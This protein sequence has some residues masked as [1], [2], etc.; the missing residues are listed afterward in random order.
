MEIK[1]ELARIQ[2]LQRDGWASIRTP[3]NYVLV[4]HEY[5]FGCRLTYVKR[6]QQLYEDLQCSRG[7]ATGETVKEIIVSHTLELTVADLNRIHDL[8]KFKYCVNPKF[9]YEIGFRYPKL[10]E[11][12]KSKGVSV[13]G[14][15]I[16]DVNVEVGRSMGYDVEKCDVSESC[17]D[18][19]GWDL[20]VAYHVL[21]HVS[22][23]LSAVKRIHDSMSHGAHFH[24]EVPIE[25][26]VP[27]LRYAHVFPFE[28]GDLT[29]MCRES[30]FHI[31]DVS[32]RTHPGGP[33]IE[34]CLVQKL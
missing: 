7:I 5:S 32:D 33:E 10:L 20:V 29:A 27:R 21:E 11:W 2:K 19:A 28:R 14:C 31:I 18:L 4:P 23:P 12:Y 9:F 17:P 25:P 34:R 26:G 22:E 6:Q 24:V 13:S 15:D 8:E 1:D 30:G 3:D 16:V